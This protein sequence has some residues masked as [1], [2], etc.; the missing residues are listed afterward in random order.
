MNTPDSSIV[1]VFDTQGTAIGVGFLISSNLIITC[2]HVLN[3]ASGPAGASASIMVDFPLVD[4]GYKISGKIVFLDT[5]KDIACLDISGFTPNGANPIKLVIADNLWGHTFRTFGFPQGYSDGVWSSGVLRSNT[6]AGW[7]QVE[8]IKDTGYSIKP[9][10]SGGPVWDDQLKSV[11]GIITAADM[12]QSVKAAFCIPARELVN[13]YPALRQNIVLACPYRSLDAFEEYDSQ[14]FFGRDRVIT[15]LIDSIRREPRFLAVLGPSGSGKSSVVKAGLIPALKAGKVSGSNRWQVLTI[16]PGLQPFAQLEA[17]GLENL[18]M[19]LG[20]SVSRWYVNNPGVKRLVIFIDQFEE[21]LVSTSEIIKSNFVSELA[22]LLDSSNPCTIIMTMRDDFY[23]RFQQEA[24]PLANWLERGLVNI[25]PILEV[26]ELHDMIEKP[27]RQT[28]I[29]FEDGLVESIIRDA[30]EVDRTQDS[31]RSTILPLLEF[32][33]TQMWEIRQSNTLSH[34]HYQ[35]IG[36]VAGGLSQWA[37]NAYHSLKQEERAKARHIFT[38]LVNLGDDKQG[39]PH[40]KRIKKYNEIAFDQITD[41]VVQKLVQSRLLVTGYDTT[42]KRDQIEIIHEALIYKWSQLLKWIEEDQEYLS[43][44]HQFA[45]S[46]VDWNDASRDDG[47]LYRGGRLTKLLQWLDIRNNEP[48][49]RLEKEFLEESESQERIVEDTLRRAN[50]EMERALRMKDEF[51]A[52]MSH[53][54]RTPLNA[55]L[56]L[57]ESLQEEIAGPLNDKQRK[58]IQVVNES[59][60]HLLELINDILDLSRIEA[61]RITLDL[62]EVDIQSVCQSSLRLISQ[63]AQK[64]NQTVDLMIE[65]GV[66]VVTADERRLKQMLVNLL[67]NAVKYTPQNGR[68]GLKVHESKEEENITFTIWDNGIG[69]KQDDLQRLFKPFVQLD[70]GLE[71]EFGGTGLGLSLVAQMARLHGGSVSVSSEIGKGSQFF[72]VLPSK[73]FTTENTLLQVKEDKDL[74]SVFVQNKQQTILVVED[75]IQ[76]VMLIT[77]YLEQ[78]GY[79]IVIAQDGLE[80][81]S[82][83]KLEKPDLILMDV[84]MPRMGGFEATQKI[85]EDKDFK[86]IPIIALTALAMQG[87]RERCIAAGM[88]EYLSKPINLKTLLNV[89]RTYLPNQGI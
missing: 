21:L 52:N 10:F 1:R 85:R 59:A 34:Y 5:N 13:A 32:A 82:Q 57:S 67:S 29:L 81:I 56:G 40:T 20:N 72:I 49:S 75:T 53:E 48:L 73:P 74:S 71:R 33:L 16:R 65:E 25:P 12:D 24:I 77:D 89:I 11:V 86:D 6:G 66:G 80:A 69:I 46:A 30:I 18:Q 50:A 87:D 26:S 28:G 61:G 17:V 88:N 27:G 68:L 2:A 47:L 43:V 37:D 9:G 38:E 14:Y 45:I 7:L 54:L 35:S 51:L 4:S 39:I 42:L 15:K 31:A 3:A 44:R 60:R 70:S 22:Q 79:K 76:A 19:G 78:A 64:K 8:D 83:S 55:I 58:Y 23:S 63:I 62:K 84:Q 36:G 41:S